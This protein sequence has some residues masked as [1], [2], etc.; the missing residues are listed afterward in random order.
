MDVWFDLSLATLPWHEEVPGD[1]N[2][3]SSPL[4][5]RNRFQINPS[6]QHCFYG[7][8]GLLLPHQIF[9]THSQSAL[10]QQ[11]NILTCCRDL[12]YCIF[13]FIFL[14]FNTI[15]NDAYMYI[16][17]CPLRKTIFEGIVAGNEAEASHDKDGRR[18][19]HMG[20]SSLFHAVHGSG[21]V[22]YCRATLSVLSFHSFL[23]A[24]PL[25][26]FHP[27]PIF[28]SPLFTQSYHLSC[29]LPLFLRP[30]CFFHLC[31]LC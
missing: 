20:S 11:V 4:E 29:G 19:S 26:I 17:R 10:G 5:M 22:K 8:M 7:E 24:A 3:I 28:P 16:R 13:T 27:P 2:C 25:S 12:L 6:G 23:S 1:V 18:I 9:G 21:Q 30:L 15:S 14:T 31:S